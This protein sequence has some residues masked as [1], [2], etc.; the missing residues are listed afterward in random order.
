MDGISQ[1]N[2]LFFGCK[3]L[4]YV[5]VDHQFDAVYVCCAQNFGGKF[6]AMCPDSAAHGMGIDLKIDIDPGASGGVAP[7]L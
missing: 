4:G 5:P 1:D 3:G 6:V 2:V 7:A